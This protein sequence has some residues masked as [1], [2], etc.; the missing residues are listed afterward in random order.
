MR[1]VRQP[2]AGRDR[3]SRQAAFAIGAFVAV[4]VAFAAAD[5]AAHS[6]EE[7]EEGLSEREYYVQMVERPAPAFTLQDA[8]GRQIS[9]ADY[10]GKVVV[11]WF[12]YATCPDVCPLQSRVLAGV[13]ED[14]N[15]TAMR[16]LVQF[17]AITTDPEQDTPEV[18]RDYG[19]AQGLDP[20]NWV[21]LTKGP[22]Q[23]DEITRELAKGYGVEFVPTDDGMQMHGTVTHLIDRDGVMRARYHGLKFNAT[24]FIM[25]VNAM[26]NDY[27]RRDHPEPSFWDRLPSWLRGTKLAAPDEARETP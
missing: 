17:V 25:H 19:P 13:Q 1:L 18:L 4:A 2:A 14:I 21:F 12:I 8:G 23:P 9:L 7:V 26:T 15:R 20:A 3:R 27:G 22:D 10:R 24:N 5:V 11:L 6:L 16:D